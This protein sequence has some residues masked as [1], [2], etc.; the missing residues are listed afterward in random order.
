MT[1]QLTVLLAGGGTGG[2][3][4]PNAAVLERLREADA[5]EPE[6]SRVTG[7]FILSRRPLDGQIADGLGVEWTS[8]VAE[9]F[10]LR[11]RVLWRFLSGF[12]EAKRQVRGVIARNGGNPGLRGAQPSA[13]GRTVMVATGGFVSGPAVRAAKACSVPVALVNLDAVPGRANAWLAGQVDK[14]FSVYEHASLRGAERVGLPLRRTAV[15]GDVEPEQARCE[16]SLLPDRRTLLVTAGSQGA[17]SINRAMMALCEHDAVRSALR[18]RWQVM[19]LAGESMRDEVAKAYAAAGIEANVLA[20]CDTMGLAWRSAD[21]AITRAGA[22]SVAEAWAN[23]VPSVFLPYPYHKDEH[24]RLNAQ[25]MVDTGGAV[26][27]RDRVEPTAN[28]SE[29][30]PLLGP[31][32]TADDRLME[33]RA[34]LDRDPP[35]DGAQAVA[36][37]VLGQ[38]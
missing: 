35:G 15:R 5:G 8:I 14:V 17:V 36:D 28:V 24:Q 11:P 1:D 20:F 26:L 37:W 25:P 30:A 34:A 29:L 19:H 3:I 6:K 10:G 7:H 21:L 13:L 12:G 32:L 27:L 18:E 2:H 9:P 4:F 16:L 31:M 33:M 23:R 22:G 38:A